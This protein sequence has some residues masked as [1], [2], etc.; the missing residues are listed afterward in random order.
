M[1]NN[2]AET[3]TATVEVIKQWGIKAISSRVIDEISDAAAKMDPRLTNGQMIEKIWEFWKN[4]GAV[5]SPVDIAG[6]MARLLAAAGPFTENNKL[7]SEVRSL[8]NAYARAAKTTLSSAAR[9]PPKLEQDTPHERD[10]GADGHA[11]AA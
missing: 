4:N 10:T 11:A 2:H 5:Q 6:E 1:S 9:K 7:P 3:E 8:L